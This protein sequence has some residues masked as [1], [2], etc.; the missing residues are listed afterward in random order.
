MQGMAWCPI[1]NDNV[2]V[3]LFLSVYNYGVASL[4]CEVMFSDEVYNVI[5]GPR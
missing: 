4:E 1:D 3:P 5:C 2:A